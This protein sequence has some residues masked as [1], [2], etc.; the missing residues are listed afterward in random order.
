MY[1][2][3]QKQSGKLNLSASLVETIEVKGGNGPILMTL[4]N[5]PRRFG[6]DSYIKITDSDGSIL[7]HRDRNNYYY[8]Y[9]SS[10]SSRTKKITVEFQR[11]IS[12]QR[13]FNNSYLEWNFAGGYDTDPDQ[14]CDCC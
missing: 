7:F 5:L 11:T 3:Y 13:S 2:Y 10:F 12:D 9:D 14:F 6:H 1:R 8:Q 4:R